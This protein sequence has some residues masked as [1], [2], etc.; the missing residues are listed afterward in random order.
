MTKDQFISNFD[1]VVKFLKDFTEE[2]CFNPIRD[3]YKFTITPNCRS[4]DKHLTEMEVEVLK[5][6]NS[7]EGKELSA[8]QAVELLYHNNEV[9]LWINITIYES[10]QNETI[11]DLFCSRR[12]RSEKELNHSVDKYPPFHPL[13]PIPPDSFRVEKD[14]KFDVNWKRTFDKQ[15]ANSN[16]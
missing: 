7:Y 1:N 13:V 6:L 4:A 8:Q 3:S 2:H 9:P 10:R 15:K 5:M 14:G 16:I 11:I 12:F